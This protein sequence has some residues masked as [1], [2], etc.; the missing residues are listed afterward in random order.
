[1]WNEEWNLIYLLSSLFQFWM[2]I[3]IGLEMDIWKC[4]NLALALKYKWSE[5][6]RREVKQPH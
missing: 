5:V 1:L 6:S 2:F 3:A 4:E